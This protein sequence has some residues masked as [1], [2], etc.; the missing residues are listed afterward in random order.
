MTDA[1]RELRRALR[2]AARLLV[3]AFA[4]LAATLAGLILWVV[5]GAA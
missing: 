1:E 4:F 2:N 3:L 5:W